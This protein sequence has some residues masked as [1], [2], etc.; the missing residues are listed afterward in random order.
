MKLLTLTIL[1]FLSVGFL[2]AFSA[3]YQEE[4]VAEPSFKFKVVTLN[5]L[6]SPGSK[7]GSI[8]LLDDDLEAKV[9]DDYIRRVSLGKD[10][11][12]IKSILTTFSNKTGRSYTPS[13][14]FY[15]YNRYG[16]ELG[17]GQEIWAFDSVAPGA[18]ESGEDV[19][20]LNDYDREFRYSNLRFPQ[21]FD[22]PFA[23]R[24]RYD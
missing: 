2:S 14:R 19:Y 4:V 22:Q 11:G 6:K 24:V 7:D 18:V 21:D 10:R 15:I 17:W 13:V 23:V 3:S 5:D 20:M 12:S 1:G 16:V 8:F 9:G